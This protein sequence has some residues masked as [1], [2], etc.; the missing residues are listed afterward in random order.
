MIPYMYEP[1]PDN[2][3]TIRLLVLHPRRVNRLTSITGNDI[4]CDLINVKLSD[5]PHYEALSYTWGP[6]TPTKLIHMGEERFLEIRENLYTSLLTIRKASSGSRRLWIDA[7]CINQ[8]DLIEKGHEIKLMPKIYHTAVRALVWLGPATQHSR[9]FLTWVKDLPSTASSSRK[10]SP[11]VVRVKNRFF[12]RPYWSRTW[13]IQELFM[14]KELFIMC[15]DHTLTDSQLYRLLRE[16]SAMGPMGPHDKRA[17]SLALEARPVR[18]GDQYRGGRSLA[19]LLLLYWDTNCTD[20][21]D[22]VYAFLGI[23]PAADPRNS[24]EVDYSLSS[25][26]LLKR[27]QDHY[28]LGEAALGALRRALKVSWSALIAG[29]NVSER[30]ANTTVDAVKDLFLGRGQSIS[31]ISATYQNHDVG[32]NRCILRESKQFYSC[33]TLWSTRCE[34]Q[35]GDL[36]FPTTERKNYSLLIRSQQSGLEYIGSAYNSSIVPRLF[37]DSHNL[38]HDLLDMCHQTPISISSIQSDG[39]LNVSFCIPKWLFD[40]FGLHDVL[41][42]VSSDSLPRELNSQKTL[43]LEGHEVSRLLGQPSRLKIGPL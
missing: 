39:G 32:C 12:Q 13:I 3:D 19:D 29:R 35:S 18:V 33:E 11:T 17:I 41:C 30:T 40:A 27:V 2:D 7:L 4:H 25:M 15:G 26:E 38:Q 1:L 37:V 20:E 6:P 36:C 31:H 43:E 34:I 23:L 21:R 10:H 28:A 9:M 42:R 24:L 14:A 16:L 22:K 5:R 8:D